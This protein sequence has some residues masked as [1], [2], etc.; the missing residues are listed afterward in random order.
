MSLKKCLVCFDYYKQLV[1][2]TCNCQLCQACLFSWAVSFCKENAFTDNILLPCPFENCGKPLLAEQFL[3]FITPHQREI[4]D[5]YLLQ[6]Y[7][8][9]KIDVQNCP[10]EYCN[11]AG[12]IGYLP[13]SCNEYLCS[14]CGYTWSKESG[15]TFQTK[16]LTDTLIEG[17]N[18]LLSNVVKRFTGNFCPNCSIHITKLA[19]C[20]H[21]V[22]KKCNHAFCWKCLGP[23]DNYI[24]SGIKPCGVRN[25]YK[26]FFGVLFTVLCFVKASLHF[27]ILNHALYGLLWF[28]KFIVF[29]VLNVLI[30]LALVVVLMYNVYKF[31]KSRHKKISRF[32]IRFSINIGFIGIAIICNYFLYMYSIFV[33]MWSAILFI[34]FVLLFLFLGSVAI[35]KGFEAIDAHHKLMSW[36]YFNLGIC[37][38]CFVLTCFE[39]YAK[40]AFFLLL[41]MGFILHGY[42]LTEYATIYRSLKNACSTII[43]I[44][45]A[46]IATLVYISILSLYGYRTVCK[47]LADFAVVLITI[48]ICRK[49]KY[50]RL[51][52]IPWIAGVEVFLCYIFFY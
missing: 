8:S 14:K 25:F 47:L 31:F 21:V 44:L 4:V 33:D 40:I 23:Y 43:R 34:C 19:G 1:Q 38:F 9:H 17:K 10:K 6:N 3:P 51:T 48:Y 49:T 50:L 15:K 46:I 36:E 16:S 35:M 20:S 27:P 52:L 39:Y 29:G 13:N 45:L 11:F 18:E 26:I 37:V 24:H 2:L 41:G 5:K 32:F 22:C 42:R 28:A 7:L 12:I 30:S